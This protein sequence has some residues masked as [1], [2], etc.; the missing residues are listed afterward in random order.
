M[1]KDMSKELPP[2]NS[3]VFFKKV[4]AKK[5]M[6]EIGIDAGKVKTG[7]CRFNKTDS[8]GHH[9]TFI[10]DFGVCTGNPDFIIRIDDKKSYETVITIDK[11]NLISWFN[12]EEVMKSGDQFMQ[13]IKDKVE[14]IH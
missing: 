2:Y 8:S 14:N 9:F 5:G 11:L 12:L 1:W 10:R 13:L 4:S 6:I 3:T 7:I